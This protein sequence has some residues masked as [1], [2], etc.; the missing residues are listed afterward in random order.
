[1]CKSPRGRTKLWVRFCC[2]L[3]LRE[4]SER[5]RYLQII[6]RSSYK[7]HDF[8]FKALFNLL[9][10]DLKKDSPFIDPILSSERKSKLMFW[11]QFGFKKKVYV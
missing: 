6:T 8:I 2:D 7:F 10:I 5:N 1:M 9:L 3:N 4:S 11:M